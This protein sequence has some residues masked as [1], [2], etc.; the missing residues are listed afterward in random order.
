MTEYKLT[1]VVLLNPHVHE[2]FGASVK[3][4]RV[5]NVEVVSFENAP[6]EIGR[7]ERFYYVPWKE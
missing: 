6:T 1:I 5:K 3:S 2:A 4:S 7:I